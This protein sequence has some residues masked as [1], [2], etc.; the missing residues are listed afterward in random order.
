MPYKRGRYWVGQVRK[1]REKKQKLFKKKEKAIEWEVEE[2]GVDWLTPTTSSNP[3]VLQWVNKYLEFAE[4]RFTKK[5]FSEKRHIFKRFLKAV[6]PELKCS[7]LATRT[8]LDY[9]RTQA[10]TRSGH[11][12]NKERKN[13]LAAWHWGQRYLGLAGPNPFL[14]DKFPEQRRRRYIPPEGDYWKVV[15]G[16][17][18]QDRVMLVTFLHTAGRRGEVFRLRWEDVD[19]G[20]GQVRLGTRKRVDGSMEFDWV[21]MTKELEGELKG[22]RNQS[23]W[24]FPNPATGGAD[25]YQ[26]RG[27]WMRRVCD[28]VGVKRFGLHAIR[29]LTASILADADVP[30]TTIQ[31]ILRH[32]SPR[33]TEVY[34][35]GIRSMRESMRVLE[36]RGK[37][38]KIGKVV[39]KNE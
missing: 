9:F 5:V 30:L 8:A 33:T 34:L 18:G 6:N 21:P 3:T 23:E 20:L 29:H 7:R 15:N 19:F 10:E 16:C 36:R 31:R 13:L 1:G 24:V 39:G 27:K 12:S 28:E 38:V 37:V 11:A 26:E 22:H 14:T 35:H 2:K 4:A 25:P 32:R 17:E